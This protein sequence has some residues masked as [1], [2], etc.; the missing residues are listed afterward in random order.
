MLFSRLSD[1]TS[2]A[3]TDLQT[4]CFLDEELN[5]SIGQPLLFYGVQRTSI[6]N[7]INFCYNT[8]PDTYGALAHNSAPSGDIFELSNY[9]MPHHANEL[10]SVST[11]PTYNLN[12][13]SEIDTYNLTDYAGQNNSLFLKNYQEY[14]T[15][16]YNKKTRLYRYSAILPLKILLQLTLDDKVI[17][18]TKLFTINSMTTKLQSGET[19]FELL[20][21]APE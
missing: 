2:N 12:F 1:L 14:I 11:P 17:V 19:E 16:V 13:G 8:R 10:G 15:R 5:P 9:Y 20:N 4:G 7:T 18:G 6:T 21:E 3:F